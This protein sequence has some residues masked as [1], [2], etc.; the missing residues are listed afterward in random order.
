[1]WGVL[2]GSTFVIRFLFDTFI[3]TTDYGPRSAMLTRA[4][5]A[6]CFAAGFRGTW[7]AGHIGMGAAVTLATIIVGFVVAV[8]GGIV[9]VLIVG[10]F[11][12]NLDVPR[13]L[14]DALEVP[15][16]IMLV[17]G[18]AVGILGGTIAT[19]LMA[20]RRRRTDTVS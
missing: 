2:L 20:V 9:A 6:I 12:N 7:R 1:V 11:S 3:P 17:V 16:P 13:A 4:G 8:G 18:G 10:A 19:G 5:L 15:L 14:I